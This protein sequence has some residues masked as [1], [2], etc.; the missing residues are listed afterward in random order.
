MHLKV[1]TM[2]CRKT[3][4]KNIWLEEY[5][6]SWL[7]VSKCCPKLV[8]FTPRKDFMASILF[9]LALLSQRWKSIKKSCLFYIWLGLIK[10]C[11]F[12]SL[13]FTPEI[14]LGQSNYQNLHCNWTVDGNILVSFGISAQL[15]GSIYSLFSR[16]NNCAQEPYF[17]LPSITVLHNAASNWMQ[18][19]EKSKEEIRPHF[20]KV[21]NHFVMFI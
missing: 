4:P 6:R 10:L 14:N 1:L 3:L 21:L 20:W 9:H 2:F 11:R 8:S 12:A 19:A 15:Q 16:N 17:I 5:T 18:I 7:S 13:W